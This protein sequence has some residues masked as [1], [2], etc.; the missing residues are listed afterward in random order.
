MIWMYWS[1]NGEDHRR[2]TWT[3]SWK[4]ADKIQEELEHSFDPIRAEL[5]RLK[6]G[7][8]RERVMLADASSEFLSDIA[9]RKKG[10]GTRWMIEYLAGKTLCLVRK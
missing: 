7:A 3:R 10:P 5:K 9:T 8:Q 6:E 1:Q 4:K 2:T